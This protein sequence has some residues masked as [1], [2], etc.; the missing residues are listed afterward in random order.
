MKR[1]IIIIALLSLDVFVKYNIH[2]LSLEL[3]IRVNKKVYLKNE[4][5]NIPLQLQKVAALFGPTCYVTKTFSMN[6][7]DKYCYSLIF[8]P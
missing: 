5:Q 2:G 7:S 3:T 8:T 4:D 1:A 6:I